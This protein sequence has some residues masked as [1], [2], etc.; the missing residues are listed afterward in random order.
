M[1]ETNKIL[2]S[3]LNSRVFIG[4]FTWS[5]CKLHETKKFSRNTEQFKCVTTQTRHHG[6][7]AELLIRNVQSQVAELVQEPSALLKILCFRRANNFPRRYRG[8][9]LFMTGLENLIIYWE[10][11][12]NLGAGMQFQPGCILP[13]LLNRMYIWPNLSTWRWIEWDLVSFL[14]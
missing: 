10:G 2:L 14:Y 5:C 9:S 1:R 13:A 8:K 7:T 6:S 3:H 11:S 12:Y 4:D